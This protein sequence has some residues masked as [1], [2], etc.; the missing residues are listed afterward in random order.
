MNNKPW[1]FITKLAA[2]FASITFVLL[3]LSGTVSAKTV[4][5]EHPAAA[6]LCSPS[7]IHYLGGDTMVRTGQFDFAQGGGDYL[8]SSSH[9]Y[10]LIFQ[11]D[12]NLVEYDLWNNRNVVWSSGTYNVG[13]VKAVFQKDGNFVIYQQN[14]CPLWAT[15]TNNYHGDSGSKLVVDSG[16]QIIIYGTGGEFLRGSGSPFPKFV[17]HCN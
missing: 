6:A 7:D 12:G 4:Q 1:H 5:I 9:Q 16:S 3:S 17:N 14:N 15:G 13:A 8:C 2:L 11:S 10:Q